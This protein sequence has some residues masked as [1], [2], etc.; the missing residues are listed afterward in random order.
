[1][2]NSIYNEQE[3]IDL[4]DIR[5]I[6][7]GLIKQMTSDGLPKDSKYIR[8]L[9]E[10]MMSAEDSIHKGVENKIKYADVQSS[11][12][13]KCMIAE[14]LKQVSLQRMKSNANID[15]DN[16]VINPLD[17]SEM[18]PGELDTE[19]VELDANEFMMKKIEE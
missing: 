10:V 8:L 18:V 6:R 19:P 11:S 5:N 7:R 14:M 2:D 4:E 16:A 3:K 1:M 17:D 13:T 9:N 12:E 15:V